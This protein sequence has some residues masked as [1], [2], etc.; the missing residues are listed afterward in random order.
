MKKKNHS[1]QKTILRNLKSLEI[2]TTGR[3]GETG[4]P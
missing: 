4:F 3:L 1:E 2:R